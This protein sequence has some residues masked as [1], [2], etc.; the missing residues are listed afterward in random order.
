[1]PRDRG[2][3]RDGLAVLGC[4]CWLS[5]AVG[6]RARGAVSVAYVLRGLVT[7]ASRVVHT[8][9]E[10]VR[11]PERPRSPGTAGRQRTKPPRDLTAW[12]REAIGAT[13]SASSSPA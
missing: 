12:D 6:K 9:A 10:P 1:V 3:S 2:Q 13:M 11:L 7:V 5:G 4:C 8:H